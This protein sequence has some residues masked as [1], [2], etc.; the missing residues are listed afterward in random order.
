MRAFEFLQ[1]LELDMVQDDRIQP[2]D[3]RWKNSFAVMV[4]YVAITWTGAHGR[5]EYQHLRHTGR[6]NSDQL[7]ALSTSALWNLAG[8]T[9]VDNFVEPV[10]S[11]GGKSH[12]TTACI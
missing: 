10:L 12:A 5:I 1:D 4:S 11:V 9:N 8:H 2:S 6:K 3:L 7:N